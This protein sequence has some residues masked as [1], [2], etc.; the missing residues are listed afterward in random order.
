LINTPKHP[1]VLENYP[2]ELA[3]KVKPESVYIDTTVSLKKAIGGLLTKG[4]YNVNRFYSLE[5]EKLIAAEL[6]TNNYTTVILESL[7]VTPY[8]SVIRKNFSGKVFVRTHNVESIIWDKLADSAKGFARANYLR[9]LAKDIRAYEVDALNKVDGILA[10]S[11]MDIEVFK[12]QGIETRCTLI[13]VAIELSN[14]SANLDAN[15]FFHLGVMNWQPNI[16]AVKR[17]VEIFPT[18]RQ[19]LPDAELHIAGKYAKDV[20][21]DNVKEGIIVDGFVEDPNAYSR[22]TGILVSPI[23]SGSGIR[24]K[25][26]ESMALGI[27]SVTTTLGAQGIDYINSGCLIVKDNDDEIIKACVQLAKDKNLREE[28]SNNARDYIRKNHNIESISSKIIEF[29]EHT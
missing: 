27:P 18:I 13:P 24:I 8:L 17:L 25:L 20:I 19:Q 16:E 14:E 21:K 3:Q 15:N 22:E 26:L 28:I 23:L 10:L 6:T 5:M 2:Y 9:R 1:F 12:E 29:I 4:S 7:F 11:N